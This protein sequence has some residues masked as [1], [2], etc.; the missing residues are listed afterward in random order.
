MP[1]KDPNYGLLTADYG[2][3]TARIA[4]IR[5]QLRVSVLA[6]FVFWFTRLAAPWHGCPNGTRSEGYQ[7][8]PKGT[9]RAP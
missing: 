2:R 3:I 6:D 8:V 1:A 5:G 7:R 9:K 4:R